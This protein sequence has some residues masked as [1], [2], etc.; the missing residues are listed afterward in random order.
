MHV[1]GVS[2]T[3]SNKTNIGIDYVT[4][5]YLNPSADANLTSEI[6]FHCPDTEDMF[7]DIMN[8]PLLIKYKILKRAVGT[9]N[10]W[11]PIETDAGKADAQVSIINNILHSMFLQPTIK[12]N[13]NIM[14]R[15]TNLYPYL[16]YVTNLLNYSTYAKKTYLYDCGWSDDTSGSFDGA[17]NQNNGLNERQKRIANGRLDTLCSTLIFPLSNDGHMIPPHT[18]IELKLQ[19]VPIQFLLKRMANGIEYKVHYEKIQWIIRKIMP[20]DKICQAVNEKLSRGVGGELEFEYT[21]PANHFV[22]KGRTAYDIELCRGKI[23]NEIICGLVGVDCFNGD[24]AKNPFNFGTHNLAEI[25]LNIENN[26][27]PLEPLKMDYE[28]DDYLEVYRYSLR[29]SGQYGRQTG[30][31]LGFDAFAGGNALYCFNVRQD[32]HND[33]HIFPPSRNGSIRLQLK[34]KDKTDDDLMLIVLRSYNNTIF[35]DKMRNYSGN[36]LT[37]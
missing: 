36:V 9:N 30:N 27:L 32:E 10:E 12:F 31:G 15:S 21:F 24:N 33:L 28:N 16:A 35:V 1:P 34:F 3:A 5:S 19:K 13:H 14:T 4:W 23:P 11:L 6:T 8:S 22:A 18:A 20:H 17:K 26:L 29:C 37:H 7:I 25:Q 2:Y